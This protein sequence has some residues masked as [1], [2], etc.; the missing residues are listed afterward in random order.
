MDSSPSGTLPNVTA[1]SLH[2]FRDAPCCVCFVLAIVEERCISSPVDAS[3]EVAKTIVLGWRKATVD[4][5]A[6]KSMLRV[7]WTSFPSSCL[8]RA[9][10]QIELSGVTQPSE[11]SLSSSLCLVDRVTGIASAKPGWLLFTANMLVCEGSSAH[12]RQP[13]DYAVGTRTETASSPRYIRETKIH[14]TLP[15][16]TQL[17][18]ASDAMQVLSCEHEAT[19]LHIA[20]IRA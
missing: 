20:Y 1:P 17:K 7:C 18:R 5:S 13:L 9:F 6:A 19:D 10:S 12:H 8:P 15:R 3:A 16:H 2:T 4:P 11:S 14:H